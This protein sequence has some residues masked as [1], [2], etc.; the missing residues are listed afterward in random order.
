MRRQIQQQSS[1]QED[2]A[3]SY[4]LAELPSDLEAM[5]TVFKWIDY[6]LHRVKRERLMQLMSYYE[7][8]GWIGPRAKEQLL[9][10]ARGTLQD[11]TSF[12]EEGEVLEGAN[13]MKQELEYQR[14]NEYRMTA[15][16]H[17]RSL[18]FIMKIL[19]EPV[20]P[21]VVSRWETDLQNFSGL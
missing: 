20:E 2:D 3:R 10:I 6:L 18:M 14:I 16:E 8:I 7:E 19:G 1:V 12:T 21:F 4:T 13:P 9:N 11:T 17:V 15:S 5:V